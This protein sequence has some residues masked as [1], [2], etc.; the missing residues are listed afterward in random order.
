MKTYQSREL[1]KIF[2]CSKTKLFAL[3]PRLVNKPIVEKIS[4]Y[5]IWTAASIEEISRL[6]GLK[7]LTTANKR[8]CESYVMEW[9]NIERAQNERIIYYAEDPLEYNLFS[10]P[11]DIES[12]EAGVYCFMVKMR[13]LLQNFL[14]KKKHITNP[15]AINYCLGVYE[16]K[17]LFAFEKE[18]RNTAKK[19][20]ALKKKMDAIK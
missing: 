3:I 14:V 4:R 2:N 11:I 7:I 1:C 6:T 8:Q 20:I 9:I 10:S 5:K 17:F 12:E 18:N 19:Y 16:K 13:S 15:Q